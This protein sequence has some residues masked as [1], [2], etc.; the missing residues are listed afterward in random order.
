EAFPCSIQGRR[1]GAQRFARRPYWRADQR[2]S[3]RP[4]PHRRR[5][6]PRACGDRRQAFAADPG[7][8]DLPGGWT[9][10]LRRPPPRGPPRAG[11]PRGT[12]RPIIDTLNRALNAALTT[13]E[14]RE[15]LAI[16]GADPQP[17]TPEEY[18][19]IIDRELTMW[20]DLVKA[21]G[22]NPE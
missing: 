19:A 8:A 9:C 17:S 1:A 20:S 22:I 6:H 12:P 4:Q 11:A 14:V 2:D 13:D 15:R 10:R 18:A 3:E 7:G 16:E 5:H 21:V